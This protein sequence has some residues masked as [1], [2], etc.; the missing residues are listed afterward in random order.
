VFLGGTTALVAYG[1][2]PVLTAIGGNN[3]SGIEKSVL[4]IPLKIQATD[5]YFSQP[6]SSLTVTCKDGGV[7]G[8]FLPSATLTTD[9]TGTAT[10]SY[11]LPTKPRPVT[12]T[13]SSL[14]FVSAIFHE[15]GVTGPPVK[16]SIVSG[17]NQ[18]AAPNTMLAAPL[19]VKVVD[20]NGWGVAG[21]TVNFSDNAA[22]GTFSAATVAT[23]ATG[24]ASTQYTTPGQPMVVRITGS[25]SGLTSVNLRVTVQ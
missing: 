13:C 4:P 7:G 1:K 9:S 19:V 14:G 15:T 8:V 17:N 5:A 10:V 22:G 18:I 11:Q 16:L 3:Q 25:A 6:F 24:T 2:L 20:V 23:N 21:V 12:I